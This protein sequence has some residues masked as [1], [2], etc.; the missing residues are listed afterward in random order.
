MLSDGLIYQIANFFQE[1]GDIYLS[2]QFQKEMFGQSL[3]QNYEHQK[4]VQE[5][6]DE[7]ISRLNTTLDMQDVFNKIDGL[8][9][10]INSLE[11]K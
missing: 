6:A 9:D 7:V 8:N 2:Y 3:Y 5:V 4:L 11:R 1:Q 10:K